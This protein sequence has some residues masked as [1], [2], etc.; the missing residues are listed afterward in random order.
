MG[1]G[2]GP[3]LGIEDPEPLTPFSRFSGCP[4]GPI[5][6]PSYHTQRKAETRERVLAATFGSSEVPAL[7]TIPPTL[8]QAAVTGLFSYQMGEGLQKLTT[9]PRPPA[10]LHLGSGGSP[11]TPHE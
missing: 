9:A 7:G 10:L 2:T 5:W 6:L 4:N 8:T 1:W 3:R 11:P